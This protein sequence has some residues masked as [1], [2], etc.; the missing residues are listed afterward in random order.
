MLKRFNTRP[1]V[2]NLLHWFS[3]SFLSV[4]ASRIF[5]VLVESFLS[6][7]APLEP[8]GVGKVDGRRRSE[9]R[10]AAKL[11]SGS[12]FL[13]FIVLGLFEVRPL[14]AEGRAGIFE[15]FDRTFDLMFD[16]EKSQWFMAY[17][18]VPIKTNAVDGF[19]DLHI[20][21]FF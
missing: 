2:L 5:V 12:G 7:A 17:V 9:V 19:L 15:A 3:K 6:L 16:L 4:M 20:E 1:V 13:F 18:E 14:V 11:V 8:V 10:V 21:D